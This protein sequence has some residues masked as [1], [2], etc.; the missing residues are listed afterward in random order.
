M[1]KP[2]PNVGA[3]VTNYRNAVQRVITSKNNSRVSF[4][5]NTSPIAY[6]NTA[7]VTIQNV[8]KTFSFLKV[9]ANTAAWIRFYT[10]RQKR[11][12]D[13]GRSVTTDPLSNAGVILEV[14]T[15]NVA[16]VFVSPS[17]QGFTND[18]SSNLYMKVTNKNPSNVSISVTTELIVLEE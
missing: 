12:A 17:V 3:A 6:D 5:A 9:T 13:V 14:V 7:D 10:D 18:G 2:I 15:A 1:A 8:A 4:T 16:T 11:A